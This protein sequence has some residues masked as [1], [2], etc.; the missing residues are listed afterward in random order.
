MVKIEPPSRGDAIRG[1]PPFAPGATFPEAS[2]IQAFLD[3]GKRSVAIADDRAGGQDLMRDLARSADVV[4]DARGDGLLASI[5]LDRPGDGDPVV[6]SLSW[7]GADGPASGWRGSDA[8]VQAM[9]AHIHAIGPQ[10]G[11]PIVPG[12]YQAQISAGVTS[13]VAVMAAVLGR[14][15]DGAGVLI[16]Q[17]VFEAYLAY[18]EPG[19]V[20][21]AYEGV[22]TARMG[23]NRFPPVYPQTIYPAGEGWLGITALTPPQWKACCELLGLE[24]L[25]DDPRFSTSTLR[26]R[27]ADAL[28]IHM[29]EALKARPAAEW[30]HDAQARRLTFALVPDLADM[31]RLEHFRA[32]EV[33]AEFAHPDQGRFRAPAI[34]FKFAA[35]PVRAGGTAPRL[36][37]DGETVL[38]DRLK[39]DGTQIARLA[40]AGVI[41]M[42]GVAA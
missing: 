31:E 29:I 42:P 20:R 19:A 12:G 27:N 26:N 30:F 2:G 28:D 8:V 41:E 13:Y 39:M 11:P 24:A 14:M 34:P 4:I 23:L 21:Y 35:T 9:A 18:A 1:L 17:S 33:F 6:L 37:A 10:A 3:A 22:D 5:G 7:F 16:E 25:I 15:G 38:R 36:G 32:R 40:G